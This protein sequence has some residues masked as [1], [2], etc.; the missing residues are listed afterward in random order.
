VSFWQRLRRRGARRAVDESPAAPPPPAAT[1][2]REPE[3]PSP[4]E[5]LARGETV[6]ADET[7]SALTASVGSSGER[8]ALELVEAALR[9]GLATDALRVK[10]AELALAR[11]EPQRALALLDALSSVAGLLLSADAWAELGDLP[12]ALTLV[13]RVLVRDF[14]APG[15]RERHAR[16]RERLGGRAPRALSPGRE[17]TVLTADAPETSLRIVAEAGRGGAGTVYEAIDDVLER[18]VALKVYHEPRAERAK[19]E[20]EARTAVALAGAG[21]V[22]VFDVDLE[23]GLL[24]MEWLAGGSLKQRLAARD[25]SY[26]LPLSRWLLPLLDAIGRVHAAGV[27]H[28]DL[29]PANVMF[30]APGEPVL[31][32]FGLAQR[33]D[34]AIEGGS[35]GYMSPERV[36]GTARGASEDLYAL[37]RLVE[38]VW[39]ALELDPSLGSGFSVPLLGP[40]ETRPRSVAEVRALVE[41]LA[42]RGLFPGAA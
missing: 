42:R 15:A 22:R 1:R 30:R 7:L 32:D 2:A 21:I 12:R 25:R 4:L 41:S 36:L 17:P 39:A 16:W 37:G 27:V 40:V 31:S 18:R 26:L 6:P 13:E 19:L 33:A 8:R 38:D 28:A 14:E 10:A 23:R 3:P 24:V 35:V 5:R 29:K 9:Q 34:A 20:R 11:G